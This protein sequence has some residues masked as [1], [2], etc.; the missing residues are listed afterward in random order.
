M[1]GS[2]YP[3]ARQ[4]YYIRSL[5]LKRTRKKDKV[6]TTKVIRSLDDPQSVVADLL[7][8]GLTYVGVADGPIR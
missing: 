3:Q 5:N 6:I 7:P 8:L 2:H 4:Q 1:D